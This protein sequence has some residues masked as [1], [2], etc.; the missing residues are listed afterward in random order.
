MFG[1]KKKNEVGVVSEESKEEKAK[2]ERLDRLNKEIVVHSMPEKYR[3]ERARISQTKKVGIIIIFGGAILMI[4]VGAV[5]YYFII[6]QP[7]IAPTE[8]IV[9][10]ETEPVVSEPI[11]SVEEGTSATETATTVV[12]EITTSTATSS[13]IETTSQAEIQTIMT[14]SDSD[15]LN[16]K[17]EELL[18]INS[19]N[20][21]SDGDGY[22]DFA[23]LMNL[24]DPSGS[25]KL[26]DNKNITTFENKTYGYKVLYPSV[27]IMSKAG[28]DDSIIFSSP[29]N[30][31]LQIVTQQNLSLDSID[32]WYK[33]QFSVSTIDNA[34][35]ISFDNW[36][37]IRS[38]D[39]LV[40]Y[41]SDKA[42]K[43]V[44]ALSYTSADNQP[45]YKNI[46]ELLVRSFEVK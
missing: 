7:A 13:E 26:A 35:K 9:A 17:E 12:S 22:S 20:I 6:K 16:N 23:E 27:W 15:G 24:Y 5:F 34:D 29:D 1:F 21:D 19:N 36:E 41:L 30:H 31:F 4:A 37:G 45:V 43:Y 8:Q 39:G 40:V 38:N 18:N 14:D 42:R 33:K 11:V 3:E 2:K 25:G 32:S 10:G 44:F 46:F 28:G